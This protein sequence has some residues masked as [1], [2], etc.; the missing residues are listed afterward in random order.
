MSS[1]YYL[2][3]QCNNTEGILPSITPTSLFNLGTHI[4]RFQ[5]WQPLPLWE[6]DSLTWALYL[7]TVLFALNLM[8]SGQNTLFQNYASWRLPFPLPPVEA[9]LSHDRVRLIHYILG[10]YCIWGSPTF[11][12]YLSIYFQ[13]GG[14]TKDCYGARNQSNVRTGSQNCSLLIPE[15]PAPS[16]QSFHHFIILSLCF[17]S[18][19]EQTHTSPSFLPEGKVAIIL[20]NTVFC[21]FTK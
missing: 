16:P 21:F 1:C 13:R 2:W 12:F 11:W 10:S 18:A 9:L 17:F 3:F 19:D 4:K 6:T 5:N 7:C 20:F 14:N 8:I 15:V